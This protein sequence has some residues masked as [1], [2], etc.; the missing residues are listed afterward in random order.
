MLTIIFYVLYVIACFILIA[1]VLLQ[2]GKADAAA[3]FGGGSQS[4]FGPRGAQ[5]A[6]QK[7]TLGAAVAFML[8]AFLFS[9]NVIGPKSVV[10]GGDLDRP[11]QSHPEQQQQQQNQPA[12]PSPQSQEGAAPA[13]GE[14]KSE[15]KPENKPQ[16]NK[17]AQPEQSGA[18]KK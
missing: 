8:I 5:T 2:S 10:S 15:A 3:V 12:L 6:L 14:N 18:Q 11:A 16:E 4:A 7:I 1:V 9:L 17:P 13:Q